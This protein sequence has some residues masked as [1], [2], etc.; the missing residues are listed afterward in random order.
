MGVRRAWLGIVLVLIADLARASDHRYAAFIG[1][2][3]LDAKGSSL[4]LTGLHLGG[5]ATVKIRKYEKFALAGD[6]SVN[7]W[8]G[9]EGTTNPAQITFTAGPR[10]AFLGK[11]HSHNKAFVHVMVFG[12]VTRSGTE[13]GVESATALAF[14]VGYDLAPGKEHWGSRIQ[15]DWLQPYAPDVGHGVRASLGLLYRFK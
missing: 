7:S 14:G 9:P 2:S 1:P 5:E 11:E 10:W 13:K 4:K 3:Y 12:F 15:I 6:L 8:G